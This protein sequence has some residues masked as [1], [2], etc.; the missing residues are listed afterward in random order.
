MTNEVK[1]M[2]EKTEK[3]PGLDLFVN[4]NFERMSEEDQNSY[5]LAATEYM[6]K[7][8]SIVSNI[9]D[10]EETIM[11]HEIVFDITQVFDP[12]DCRWLKEY[13]LYLT[14]YVYEPVPKSW[15]GRRVR[16]L[17]K[18]MQVFIPD[19]NGIISKDMAIEQAM[20]E[21]QEYIEKQMKVYNEWEEIRGKFG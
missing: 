16:E 15:L 11:C 5:I 13:P 21:A 12:Y 4:L 18:W 19:K 20:T 2:Y 10:Q 1:Q 9:Q 7:L 14:K 8:K 3:L 6:N 17:N